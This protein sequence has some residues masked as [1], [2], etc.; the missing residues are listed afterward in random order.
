MIRTL[1]RNMFRPYLR[2]W[3]PESPP[4][5]Y[6]DALNGWAIFFAFWGTCTVIELILVWFFPEIA[7]TLKGMWR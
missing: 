2:T 5:R 3:D 7:A 6:F 1:L 4:Q